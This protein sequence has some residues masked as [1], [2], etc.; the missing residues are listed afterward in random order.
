MSN[1][2]YITSHKSSIDFEVTVQI[3]TN[4]YALCS[5][6]HP[7]LIYSERNIRR[8]VEEESNNKVRTNYMLA[9]LKRG[10]RQNLI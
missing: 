1:L 3:K 6:T 8:R 4:L 5:S 7:Q 9:I 10:R 2:I